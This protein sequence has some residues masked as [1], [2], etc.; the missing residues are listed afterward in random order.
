MNLMYNIV[1]GE[2]GGHLGVLSRMFGDSLTG[3]FIHESKNS[4]L[5]R[6]NDQL[7]KDCYQHT[8]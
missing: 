2:F 4:L 6:V 7:Q 1:K 3:R 5:E 8:L